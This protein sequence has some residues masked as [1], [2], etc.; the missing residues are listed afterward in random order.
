MGNWY[1]IQK[2]I[3]TP[4]NDVNKNTRTATIIAVSNNEIHGNES[5]RGFLGNDT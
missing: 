4:N 1:E 5:H 2:V 3:T